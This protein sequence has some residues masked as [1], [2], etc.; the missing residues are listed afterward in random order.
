MNPV[1]GVVEG[2]R[3]IASHQFRSLLTVS[4]VVLGVASLMAMFAVVEGM[5]EGM[6]FALNR[7]GGVER[8]R[9]EDAEV[10]RHQESIREISP[11]RTY[12]DVEALRSL[13]LIEIVSPEKRINRV[14]SLFHENRQFAAFGVRGV[15]HSYLAMNEYYQ[16]GRGR[17]ISDLDVERRNRVLVIGSAVEEALFRGTGVDPVGAR[18]RVDNIGFTVIGVFERS[19]FRMLNDRVF[20]PLST[21]MELFF[22]ANVV[23][24]IDQGPDR[25]LND[26]SVKVADYGRFEQALEQ[27]RAV[28]LQTHRGIQDFGFRT[29]E[30][31]FE[32]IEGQVK[33][34]RLSGGMVAVV[35]LLAGGVGITNIML[36]SIKE[37]TREIG[38]RRAIGAQPWDIFSQ[39]TIEV[40]LLALIGGA[41]GVAAGYG[42]IEVIK[43]ISTP[44]RQ[45]LLRTAHVW[46]SFASGV[47][48]GLLGG[49]VP[50]WKAATLEPIQALRY[51]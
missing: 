5:T 6:R 41:L 49:L 44:D 40:L 48:V 36:A 31:W 28:L 38:V 35:C 33:G 2:F 43:E 27:M 42:L 16:M 17:F 34:A 1:R 50:A 14:L 21:C 12:A 30:D 20:M 23:N 18:V 15:E 37:R 46:I 26:I 10:P 22:T 3:E 4:G 9:I 32:A 45:P 7:F 47:A 13:S 29:A 51:E 25:K 19:S 11:G 24:G 8:V 39:I